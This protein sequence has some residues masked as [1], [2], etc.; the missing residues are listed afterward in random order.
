MRQGQGASE[1]VVIVAGGVSLR[2]AVSALWL[3]RQV[4]SREMVTSSVAYQDGIGAL[5]F[6]MLLSSVVEVVLVDL[7]LSALW[8]RL[9][10]LTLGLLALLGLLSFVVA[11]RAYPHRVTDEVLT[12][13]YGACFELSIPLELVAAVTQRKAMITQKRTA[14]IRDGVLS[15]PVMGVTNLVV[16]LD[17]PI[18]VHLR[19]SAVADVREIR[20]FAVDPVSGA[21]KLQNGGLQ[22]ADDRV[23][24]GPP[25]RPRWAR[26]LRWAGPV[27][28]VVEIALVTTG[29]LDWRVAAGVIAVTEGILAVL[30]IAAGAALVSQYRRCRAEERSRAD[31]LSEAAFFL[32]PTP[33]A[34]IV[35]KELSFIRVLGLALARRTEG[36]RTGDVPLGYG[37]MCRKVLLGLALVLLGVGTTLLTGLASGVPWF[38]LGIILVYVSVLT[39][40]V[41]LA[42]KVRP[43]VLRGDVLLVRWGLHQELEVPL[44]TVASIDAER[45]QRGRKHADTEADYFSV[46]TSGRELVAIWLDEPITVPTRLG[47]HMLTRTILLPVDDGRLSAAAITTQLGFGVER[48]AGQGAAPPPPQ[49]RDLSPIEEVN[50]LPNGSGSPSPSRSPLADRLSGPSPARR[51]S[52]FRNSGHGATFPALAG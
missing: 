24:A 29:L 18:K 49:S 2:K 37:A 48:R 22:V 14:E 9:L 7:L 6:V 16:K 28:L 23:T 30:G 50:R 15:L 47:R 38:V 11:L 12:I 43:H 1:G 19:K 41:G 52:R 27:V 20:L 42:S 13:H 26:A 25:P 39:A 36:A 44:G 32:M 5:V 31:S 35:R 40:T 33:M 10:G 51:A 4:R 8:M 17:S 3:G 45:P 34:V 21:Q 46:P